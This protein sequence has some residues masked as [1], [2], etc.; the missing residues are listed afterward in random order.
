MNKEYD[1]L[2]KMILI[3]D[4]AVGKSSIMGRYVDG[5]FNHQFVSTIGVDFKVK[6]IKINDK[7]VKIQ[8]FDMAGQERFRSIVSVY[9]KGRHGV[10]IIFDLTDKESFRNIKIWL[11]EVDKYS[12]D[13]VNKILIGN[14]SDLIDRRRVTFEEA[15]ELAESMGIDYIE[16]SARDNINID[17][18]FLNIAKNIINTNKLINNKNKSTIKLIEGQQVNFDEKKNR[19]C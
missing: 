8:I 17:E 3:G 1:Y 5:N 15:H 14:K 18:I 16:T 7:V 6:T 12:S 2:L 4:T 11:H 10:V 9:Y 13:N 19:C